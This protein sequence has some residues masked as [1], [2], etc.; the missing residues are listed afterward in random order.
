[1]VETEGRLED[2]WRESGLKAWRDTVG[3][4][5]QRSENEGQ[6]SSGRERKM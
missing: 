5:G 2:L 1:M 4:S 3:N 6:E